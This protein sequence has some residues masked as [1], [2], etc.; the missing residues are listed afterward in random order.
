MVSGSTFP[1]SEAALLRP[2]SPLLSLPLLTMRFVT[3]PTMRATA[4]DVM[5]S[6]APP[7]MLFVGY[8]LVWGYAPSAGPVFLCDFVSLVGAATGEVLNQRQKKK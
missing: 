7:V 4:K 1:I 5:F 6:R 2:S 8:V 3:I